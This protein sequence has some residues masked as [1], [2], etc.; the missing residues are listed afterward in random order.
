MTI[1]TDRS[2]IDTLESCE[3][4]RFLEYHIKPP[5]VQ[6]INPNSVGGIQNIRPNWA[7]VVGGAVH[8]GLE[9]ALITTK[10]SSSLV[11][12]LSVASALEE[13][14]TLLDGWTPSPIVFSLDSYLPAGDESTDLSLGEDDDVW[15]SADDPY[16][17]A[18]G[19]AMTEALV[20]NYLKAN[21]GLSWL[22]RNYEILSVEE[23]IEWSF[24]EAMRLNGV[25][26]AYYSDYQDVVVMSR[27]DGV[28]RSKSDGRLYALSYKT[29]KSLDKRVLRQL[30]YDNQGISEMMAIEQ[31]YGQRVY[32][33]QMIYLL[34]GITKQDPITNTY[35][36]TSPLIRP[37]VSPGFTMEMNEYA[38]SYS[39]TD[40]A[41]KTRRVSKEFSRQNI[42]E[43]GQ[44]GIERWL[45]IMHRQFPKEM[46]NQV[47]NLPPVYR[48]EDDIKRW[49][50]SNF[51]RELN[52]HDLVAEVNLAIASDLPI[53][54]K[55]IG[56]DMAFPMHRKSCAFP[57]PCHMIKVC[58][59]GQLIGLLSGAQLNQYDL[60]ERK[61]NHPEEQTNKNENMGQEGVVGEAR[62]GDGSGSAQSEGN[63]QETSISDARG[64]EDQEERMATE[65]QQDLAAEDEG[66]G[67][68]CDLREESWDVEVNPLL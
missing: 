15:S 26:E 57:T 34:K 48:N 16:Q 64:T 45:D 68:V 25:D 6:L 55:L 24:K 5:A 39:Y 30:R 42:W 17:M 20:R 54:K 66:V 1:K 62:E 12:I 9:V 21:T 61:P 50:V 59:E 49:L 4:K 2:R 11:S 14:H 37:Y 7:F 27:P 44:V 22:L 33:V 23:E 52:T 29:A 28:L 51:L 67:A 46:D 65:T 60:K 8:R 58:H 32:G 10:A 35:Q 47:S 31:K 13:F 3:M 36:S 40:A 53:E 19:L 43:D 56:L 18:E 41:G 38:P 63:A